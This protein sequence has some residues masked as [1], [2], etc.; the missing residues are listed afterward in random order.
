M[1]IMKYSIAFKGLP[2]E[3][4]RNQVI[5]VESRYDERI[6]AFIKDHYTRLKSQ[7]KRADL[8]FVYLPMFFDDEEIK[9]KV[10]YYAPYL[11]SEII[12]KTELRSSFLLGY[13][14]HL[15]NKDEV[16][17]SFLYAPYQEMDRWVFEGQTIGNDPDAAIAD[18]VNRFTR[19]QMQCCEDLEVPMHD[20]IAP[21][22]P[23]FWE[24][25]VKGAKMMKRSVAEDEGDAVGASR[26]ESRAS[27]EEIREEDVK[28]TIEALERNVERLRL[29]G[30]PL[31]VIHEIIAKYETISRLRLTDDLR[32]ILPDF[33]DREVKMG[34]LYKAVY[35]LFLNHPEGI[36][37]QRLED[38]HR[39]L[40]NYYLQT[41]HR[42]ALTPKMVDT[43]N[44]LEYPGDNTINI[45]L[46]RIKAYFKATIDEHLAKYY[47]IT[48]VPGEPYRIALD[49]SL[50]E[51]EDE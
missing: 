41:S 22:A 32:I 8:D 13:A 49:S 4:E 50:I 17:P 1:T 31:S 29:L 25:V 45:V 24:R 36:I 9:E 20:E 3:P 19:P 28:D 47:Y 37:L 44:R 30:M 46:S 14:D 7:F 6:N 34:A 35:F 11:T 33:N 10:L 43:I 12:E 16:R 18:I 21:S 40:V 26:C 39:E 5:Y 48:G 15:E 23:S 38:Y 42:E 2:F 27:L 51:W